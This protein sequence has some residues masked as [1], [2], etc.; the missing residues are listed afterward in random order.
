MR[1][2]FLDFD[3]VLHSIDAIQH[4]DH[5]DEGIPSSGGR[6]FCHAPRLMEILESYPDVAV[7]ISSDW[8][9]RAPL[10]KLKEALGA[11]GERVMG[12]TD[13]TVLPMAPPYSAQGKGL[14]RYRQCELLA[15]HFGVED[16]R[17][18]DDHA[19][20]VFGP[21]HAT[22]EMMGRVIF[23]DPILGLDTR[24]TLG[25]ITKWVDSSDNNAAGEG[26]G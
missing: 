14:T 26:L 3:G 13:H 16:W 25:Q 20:I 1:L 4:V 8:R 21:E 15:K 10:A 23:C 6:L 18:L 19:E 22:K 9:S 17:L 11:L 2:L 7:I 12:T 5:A 24:V